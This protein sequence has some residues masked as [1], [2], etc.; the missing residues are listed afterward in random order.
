VQKKFY[1]PK[2]HGALWDMLTDNYR[3]F[4]PHI[5][6][7]FDFQEMLS[8]L[9]GELNASHTGARYGY[10][11]PRGD[12]T[13]SLG[14]FFD[15]SYKNTGLKIKSIM[16]K[17]PLV[18]AGSR[19]KE[20]I[21][22]EKIDGT[23][24]KPGMNYYPLLNRKSGKV[25]LLSLYDPK[26]EKRWE[27]KVKPISSGQQNQLLYQRWVKR[28]RKITHKLSE[29][30]I[31]YMHVRGMNDY[32]YREFIDAVM[33]EEVNR[34]ALI[35]DTRFNGGGDL[36]DDLTMFLS[37]ERYME[38]KAPDRNI[39]FESQRRWTK[40]SIVLVGESNYSDAHC[41]P[42][43]YRD[44]G[45]G[46]IVGM[47]VPGTCTFVWWERL[48]NGVVFGIPNMAVTDKSGDILE[49]KQLEPDILVRNDY[50][51]VASGID[52]QLQRAVEELMKELK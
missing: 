36:V 33:G 31:G 9:L 27:E 17:G 21:I 18:Q 30:R 32:S 6:N 29:G 46:K 2:L 24:I 50:D 52:Q 22:I 15:Q 37:G 19:I 34:E 35:V 8:E 25:V 1:D 48:Q 23:E 39:G 44:Q 43:G 4:L 45:I 12:R 42:A 47:P 41:F 26:E 10:N 5:N 13:S 51:K 40:P 16:E 3:R 38:F 28:N 49:N 7:N 14:A 11:D 20:G